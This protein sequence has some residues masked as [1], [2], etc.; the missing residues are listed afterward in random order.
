M[1]TWTRRSRTSSYALEEVLARAH[2]RTDHGQ[3][4]PPHPVELR[5]GVRPGR[6]AAHDDP[7]ER[8]DG[9][10]GSRPRRLAH[11]LDDDVDPGPGRLLHGRD[12]VVG[13]VVEHDVGAPL[14]CGGELVR[15]ARGDDRV[16]AERAADLEGRRRD[17]AADPPDQRPVPFP[18][19]LPRDEHPVRR[20]EH[21]WEG[22]GRLEGD[23]V[24]EREDL[25]RRDRDQLR[26]RPV[27]MLADHRDPVAMHQARVEDDALAD[28]EAGNAVAERLD[29]AGPVRSE[30]ARLRHRRE[31]LSHPDVEMVE[32]GSAEPDEHLP[33]PR[34]GV[35]HLLDLHDL[36][37][38]VLVDAGGEH[39]TIFA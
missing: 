17:A 3:L 37:A 35:G 36:G 22:C 1:W 30:D 28:S 23:V 4:L 13:V 12:D 31:A 10:E 33:G 18:D 38:A 14:A 29:D 24:V 6:G 2:R 7:A 27:E 32:R 5:R 15:A 34:D 26:V 11:G 39:G 19:G 21:E 16:D 8:P 20:L 9:R 25:L